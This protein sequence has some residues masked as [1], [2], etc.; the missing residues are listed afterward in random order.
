MS[1]LAP[2]TDFVREALTAGRS[3]PEI[4]AAMRDAGWAEADRARALAAFHEGFTPPVPRPRAGLDPRDLFVQA[5]L[6]G[7]LA[8]G[9]FNLVFGL[10]ALID[11]GFLEAEARAFAERPGPGI[12]LAPGEG[13]N[14][15]RV[16]L[17][18][19][20]RRFR[21]AVATLVVVAP[22]HA[23][24]ALRDRRRRAADPAAARSPARRWLAYAALLIASAVFIGSL[25]TIAYQFLTG[26]PAA[27]TLLKALV[28]AAV[29]AGVF[30]YARPG[31]E[32]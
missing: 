14:Y 15:R 27:E 16:V 24:L 11:V 17:D 21:G 2:L 32:G 12:E 26:D 1:R 28:V 9:A 20:L 31:E 29:S 3:R 6:F 10:H 23:W 30:A 8:A 5:L 19:A 22:L 7:T 18:G 13:D 25:S 4:D